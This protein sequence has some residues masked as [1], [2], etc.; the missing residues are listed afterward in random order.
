MKHIRIATGQVALIHRQGQYRRVLTEGGYWLGWG[1]AAEMHDLRMPFASRFALNLLLQDQ[2]LTNMLHVVSVADHEIALQY[3]DGNLK[4]VLKPGK[5]IFWRG[6]IE[7]RF[8]HVDLSAADIDNGWDRTLLKH[9]AMR[10]HVQTFLVESY[11]KG[12]LLRDETYERELKPGVYYFWRNHENISMLKADM[13]QQQIEVSGQEILTRDKAA[14]RINFQAIYELV[15]VQKALLENR[16]Y[17]TTLYTAI[18]LVLREYVGTMTLDELLEKKE[19][20]SPYI[21]KALEKQ[22]EALGLVIK[23]CGIKDIILPGD[24]REIMNQVLVAQK[25]AQANIITRREE[26]ASTRS[27]L[28]TAKLMEENAMLYKLKEM[29]YVEKIAENIQSISVS[30]GGQILDQLREMFSKE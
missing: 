13:R 3:E 26:T 10:E 22:A 21:L 4:T 14:L 30:G 23:S 7:Y 25:K 6:A 28:N 9:A 11:C 19:A 16:Q 12:L 29:E 1:E 17:A 2:Q 15:D 8:E 18:Q 5:H 27:L 24:V 20:V